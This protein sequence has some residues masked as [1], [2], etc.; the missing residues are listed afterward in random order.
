MALRKTLTNIVLAGALAL[1][2]AGCKNE[3]LNTRLDYNAKPAKPAKQYETI[4]GIPLSV[5]E[6]SDRCGGCVA[7]VLEVEDRPVLAYACNGIAA[8]RDIL[9]NVVKAVALVQSEIVDGDSE[10]VQLTG[11]YDGNEFRV[12]SIT[13]NGYTI[14]FKLK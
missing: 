10:E 11:R 8:Q 6:V 5:S 7:M 2:M 3:G 1:G 9:A 12:K 4:S 13:A 14:D